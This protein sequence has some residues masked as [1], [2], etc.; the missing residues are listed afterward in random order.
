[1]RDDLYEQCSDHMTEKMPSSTKLG[2]RPSSS[3]IRSNSCCVRLWVAITSEVIIWGLDLVGTF[4][5]MAQVD[6]GSGQYRNA[7]ASGRRGKC[8]IDPTLPRYGT[9][10]IQATDTAP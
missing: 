10:P 4:A 1:M 6:L 8:D 5:S 2:S 9:D 3:F 7:V